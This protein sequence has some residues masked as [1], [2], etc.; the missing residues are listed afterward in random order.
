MCGAGSLSSKFQVLLVV[1]VPFVKSLSL[2]RPRMHLP[3]G[4]RDLSATSAPCIRPVLREQTSHSRTKTSRGDYDL[5]IKWR[6]NQTRVDVDR[7]GIAA[8][9]RASVGH[10]GAL[11]LPSLFRLARAKHRPLTRPR[12]L[13]LWLDPS[14]SHRG[15]AQAQFS[16]GDAGCPPPPPPSLW[17][18][19]S[20][21]LLLFLPARWS[22]IALV[23]LTSPS[24]RPQ[25]P[26][27][28]TPVKYCGLRAIDNSHTL[29]VSPI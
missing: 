11:R 10:W 22:L 23:L 18:G 7:A 9:N 20:M 12:C 27:P 2:S 21:L 16:R 1:G 8:I 3:A 5:A 25:A 28:R 24:A 17:H 14:L 13:M 6:V 15:T 29:S 19:D 26:R 4:P